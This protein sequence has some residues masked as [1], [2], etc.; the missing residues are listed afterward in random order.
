MTYKLPE[1]LNKGQ[2]KKWQNMLEKVSLQNM[3][4]F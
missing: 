4:L 3:Y 2:K 1:D